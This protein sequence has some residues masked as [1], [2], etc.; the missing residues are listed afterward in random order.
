MYFIPEAKK[1]IMVKKEEEKG[2]K[3]REDLGISE[4]FLSLH[5]ITL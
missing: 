4:D 2:K 1:C 3:M 5:N